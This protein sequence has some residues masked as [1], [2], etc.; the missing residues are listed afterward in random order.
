MN[1]IHLSVAKIYVVVPT[2]KETAKVEALLDCFRRIHRDDL[3]LVI[4]NGNPGDET[5]ALL[6]K[7]VGVRVREIPGNPSLY[8]S[9]LMNLGLR[10]VLGQASEDDWVVFMNADVTFEVDVFA[11]LLRTAAKLG[12]CQIG[13]LTQA[14]G[15]A[16][17]SGVAVRSWL[18]GLNRHPFAGWSL[19]EAAGHPHEAVD[20]LPGRCTLIPVLAIWT[21]GLI[22]ERRLAHYGADYEYSNRL[23]RLGFPAYVCSEAVVECDVKNTGNSLYHKHSRLVE[24][25]SRIWSLKSIYNPIYRSRFICLTY[26]WYACPSALLIYFVKTI[27]EVALG[28]ELIGKIFR[29]REMGFSGAKL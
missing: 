19:K 28:G 15:H 3:Q 14:S 22:N 23:K 9:G 6:E 24:R 12:Q 2:F 21:G 29:S 10:A 13:A 16:I 18:F 26:P 17:S 20:F 27:V 25:M 7:K 5:S 4:V 1:P 11:P 8:W